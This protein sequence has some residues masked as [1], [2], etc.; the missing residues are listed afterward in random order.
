MAGDDGSDRNPTP[1]RDDPKQTQNRPPWPQDDNPLVSFRRFADEQISSMLQSVMGL[2]SIV[3]SP[4]SD[5][6]TVFNDSHDYNLVRHREDG[7]SPSDTGG[8]PED[9]KRPPAPNDDDKHTSTKSPQRAESSDPAQWNSRRRVDDSFA[10]FFG[11]GSFFDRFWLDDHLPLSS[12]I[13]P[14]AT[15][16][17]LFGILDG[18]EDMPMWPAIYIMT[19]PYSPLQLEREARYR[20]HRDQDQGIFSSLVS[21]L[22]PSSESDQTY[23]RDPAEPEWRDAFEDLL[24][25]KYG[26]PMLD[27]ESEP[28]GHRQTD[29]DWFT[30]LVQRGSLGEGWKYAPSKS[31]I[32]YSNQSKKGQE[33]E[34]GKTDDVDE[35]PVK[36]HGIG[37]HGIDTRGIDAEKADTE[38]ADPSTELDLYERFIQDIEEREQE[39]SRQFHDSPILRFLSDE[40]QRYKEE[41]AAYRSRL[42]ELESQNRNED[43]RGWLDLVSGGSKNTVPDSTVQKP[44]SES[45]PTAVEQATEKP[46][47]VS[48]S[49]TTERVRLADG[50]VRKKIIKTKRFSDGREVSN[51]S[52]KT[53]SRRENSLDSPPAEDSSGKDDSSRG[54]W[55]W[56][57]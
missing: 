14:L 41:I 11:F 3:S 8:S 5:R 18:D 54:G 36:I 28:T 34:H 40:R 4:Q 55:F 30:G 10:D 31:A 51:E 21:S 46:H 49:T 19:S 24:R 43:P 56:R 12:R 53:T 13:F 32:W 39:F 52:V 22:K 15:H 16:S 47:L 26:K 2:P 48:T 27:R 42:A 38:Q 20:A 45:S 9:S 17:S 44:S 35:F 6:W 50:S 29:K 25:V 1:S 23:D 37:I 33:G 7:G 57:R